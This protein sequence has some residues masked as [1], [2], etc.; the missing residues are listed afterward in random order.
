MNEEFILEDIAEIGVSLAGFAGIV[1]A[2]AGDKLRPADPGLWLPFW[3]MIS[4]GLSIVFA[5]LFPFLPYHFDTPERLSWAASS[6][7]LSVV[8]AGNLAL[9]TPGFLRARRDG[10]LA[11]T[12]AFDVLLYVLSFAL[13]VSQVLNAL[14]VGLA[15]SA[16][17]FLIGL[18]LMLLI[19]ALNFVFLMYVLGRPRRGPTAA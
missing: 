5:A 13:L 8:V 4:S 17:G 12:V 1:G 9:F 19:S 7:F 10:F 18:Y 14:G 16:G 6:A 2:L 3:V 15:R 11:G